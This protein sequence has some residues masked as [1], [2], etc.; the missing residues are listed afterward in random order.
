MLFSGARVN[1]FFI[2]V[3]IHSP[4]IFPSTS[5][6]L[7]AFL[8]FQSF[9]L[10]QPGRVWRLCVSGVTW[11]PPAVKNSEQLRRQAGSDQFSRWEKKTHLWANTGRI[12]K[13]N[14]LLNR[15]CL[16]TALSLFTS[17]LL[18]IPVKRLGVSPWPTPSFFPQA[19]MLPASCFSLPKTFSISFVRS[20]SNYSCSMMTLSILSW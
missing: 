7:N 5:S 9:L 14:N 4:S 16:L 18:N 15:D 12:V 19:G 11:V 17:Q 20:G 13:M 10:H 6:H 1:F 3:S 8:S 2:S